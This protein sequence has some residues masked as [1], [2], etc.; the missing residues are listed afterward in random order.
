MI[1]TRAP[2]TGIFFLILLLTLVAAGCQP[3]MSTAPRSLESVTM[4]STPALLKEADKVWQARDYAAAELY[5]SKALERNDLSQSVQAMSQSRLGQAAYHN[6]HYRQAREALE[7]AANLDLGALSDS[8]WEQAYLGTLAETGNTE[9]L[10]S[11]LKW[12]LEQKALPWQTRQDIALWYSQYFAQKGDDM[13]ALDVL[14]GFYKQARTPADRAAF[15]TTLRN[16]LKSWDDDELEAMARLAKPSNQ[17]RFPYA[18]VAF[19]RARRL[20]GDEA[21]WPHA[22]RTMRAVANSPELV[23][24]A[25]LRTLLASFEDEYG[26]PRVGLVIAVPLTGPYGSVGAAIVRGVGVAQW[27]LASTG[28]DVDVKVLNTDNPGWVERLKEMPESYSVVGGPLRG[29]EFERLEEGGFGSRIIDNRAVFGFMPGLGEV[30]E[31]REAWRF[32]SSREDEVRSLVQLAAGELGI[33]D[34]AI[35]YP[36]EEFGRAM[37]K[38][39]Y[40]EAAPLGVRI[41]GMESYDPRDLPSW[42]KSIAKLLNVPDSFSE[43]KEAP[44]PMPDF[45]AVFVPDGWRQAQNLLP[46]FFFYEGEQLVYLGPGLWSRALDRSKSV[47]EH[48]YRLAVCPGAWWK[49]SS[50]AM[51]LQDA[52]R[53]EGL[54]R[55]D[56]WVAL[57]YDF[58]RFA[59]RMGVLPAGFDTEDVNTRVAAA[60][61]MQFSMAPIKWDDNGVAT[62][63]LYLFSPRAHGKTLADPERLQQGVERATARR[64][65]RAEAYEE[66]MK[67]EAEARAESQR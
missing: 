35:F 14:D 57:G 39:F 10:K 1:R 9:R 50:G 52:L 49:G 42:N 54:G 65:R 64:I 19:E 16:G 21:R 30:Q 5:Y 23:D 31:G 26:I 20:V 38:I 34:F 45:G 46:N 12:T 40:K 62:Q 47:D 15:E 8:G 44:L 61:D 11:H 36:R 48:Y 4:L 22:W 18:L 43:N 29:S 53:Q 63:E 33:K 2:H 28:N 17:L 6:G 25:A 41:R 56:F 58:T 7:A 32:F 13:R 51:A 27:Q 24:K 67:E 59:A 37:A 60:D 66:R 55:A 3:G